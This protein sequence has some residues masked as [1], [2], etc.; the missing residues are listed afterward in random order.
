M[1]GKK[2][3]TF[4]CGNYGKMPVGTLCTSRHAIR[5]EV[6]TELITETLKDIKKIVDVDEN[7]FLKLLEKKEEDTKNDGEQEKQARLEQCQRRHSELETLLCRIYEDNALGRLPNTRY[8]NLNRQYTDE[9]DKLNTEIA[10][11]MGGMSGKKRDKRDGK[12]FI[13]LIKRHNDFEKLTPYMLNEFV[14]KIVVH[15][16]DRKGS[17]DTTQRVDIYF[18]F[19]GQVQLPEEE[20][21]PEEKAR[22]EEERRKKEETKDRLHRNYMRRKESGK[23]KEYELSYAAKRRARMLELKGQNPNTYGIPL[24]EY[25]EMVRTKKKEQGEQLEKAM[26]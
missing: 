26:L 9:Q 18:N 12:K 6:L 10:T 8:E 5:V 19:I 17:V 13:E 20:I 23:Q 3:P 2:M 4:V 7:E 21:P 15:E 14:E 1:N 22:L 11:L 16:R 24:A 25:R